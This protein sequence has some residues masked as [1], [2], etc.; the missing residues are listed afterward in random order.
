MSE[1]VETAAK[2]VISEVVSDP[3]AKKVVGDVL[4]GDLTDLGPDA[5]TLGKKVVADVVTEVS[6]HTVSFNCCCLPWSVQIAHTTTPSS[7]SKQ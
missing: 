3:T 6:T 5:D 2:N 7:Q 1:S 4:I